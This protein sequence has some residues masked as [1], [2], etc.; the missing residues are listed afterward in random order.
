MNGNRELPCH[1]L[2][3]VRHPG[4]RGI[5]DG[6]GVTTRRFITE[7]FGAVDVPLCAPCAVAQDITEL[8]EA[9]R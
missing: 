8:R 6:E 4:D 1:C 3:G 9:V 5:C 2:C 7:T